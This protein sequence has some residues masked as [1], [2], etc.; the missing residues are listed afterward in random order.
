MKNPISDIRGYERALSH[1]MLECLRNLP[2]PSFLR[3]RGFIT[4]G[5]SVVKKHIRVVQ[6]TWRIYIHVNKDNLEETRAV[7]KNLPSLKIR[8]MKLLPCLAFHVLIMVR[9]NMMVSYANRASQAAA[10]P[11]TR[12][13]QSSRQ[14]SPCPHARMALEPPSFSHVLNK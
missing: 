10:Y 14:K 2:W 11:V 3:S 4:R 8:E 1:K 12:N 6:G 7:T 9:T 13:R 5:V